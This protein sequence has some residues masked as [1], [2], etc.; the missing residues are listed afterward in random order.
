MNNLD[1]KKWDDGVGYYL[2]V[3]SETK[4]P[5]KKEIDTPRFLKLLGNVSGKSIL[6][7]GCG[8]GEFC[9]LLSS[10]GASVMGLDGS[11]R[12][13]AE[14]KKVCTNC[15]Y[16]RCDLMSEVIPFEE[17]TF[18]IV[19][20]KMLLMNIASIPLVCKKIRRI[21]KPGGI[22][23][24]D[25]VHPVR[26]ILKKYSKTSIKYDEDLDYFSEKRGEVNFQGA[27]FPFY[28]RPV[29][30]YINDILS[31]GFQLDLIKETY[32]TEEFVEKYPETEDKLRNPLTL[33]MVFRNDK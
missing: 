3:L 15:V 19:T 21:L 22:F 7:I 25:V 23:A 17:D 13:I 2:G 33:H 9:R 12:M 6:D 30:K 14:A 5:F 4:D 1:L 31:S 28:Y 26:T 18:D 24:V 27:K 20:A 11:E 16:V 29:E 32:I 10:K 8:N